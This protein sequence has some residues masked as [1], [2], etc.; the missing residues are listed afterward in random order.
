MSR[1]VVLHVGTHKTGTTSIQQFLRDQNDDLV[2]KADASY[3]NGFLIPIVHTELPL[4]TIRAD[5]TWPA[6]LR[7]PETQRTS[8]QAAAKAHVRDQVAAPAPDVLVYLHEDLSYL[9]HDDEFERLRDLLGDRAVT[10]VV[11]L[12]D[13]EAFL[14]SYASQLE[15]TGFELS[16]DPTSFAYVR[17]DSWLVDYD[18][19]VDGYRRCFGDGN[20]E[21]FDYDEIMERDGT[22]IPTFAGLLGISRT[23]LPPLDGYF[24]NPNGAHIRLPPAHLDT[25]RRRLARLYP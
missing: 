23:A 21:T 15:G 25:I 6:R 13:R 16:D 10:V 12:R 18:A 8:W 11:F 3:A 20:V 4:L 24:L 2:A 9:R 1:R 22:V 19:L 17:P 7:F 14:R 5:R